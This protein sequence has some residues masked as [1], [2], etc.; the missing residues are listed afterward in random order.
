MGGGSLG[1]DQDFG[2]GPVKL[3]MSVRHPNGDR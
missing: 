3:E 1:E 2:F